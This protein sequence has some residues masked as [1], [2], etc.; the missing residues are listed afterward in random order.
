VFLGFDF[1]LATTP[2]A[3]FVR[4]SALPIH[5]FV[6]KY[7][8]IINI[9]SVVKIEPFSSSSVYI[10]SDVFISSVSIQAIAKFYQDIC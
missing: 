6:I 8:T 10:E 1:R 4:I 7:V 2:I 3:F 5:S 9:C